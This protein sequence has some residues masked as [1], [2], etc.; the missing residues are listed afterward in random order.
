MLLGGCGKK[1]PDHLQIK[2]PE[3]EQL[4]NIPITDLASALKVM[5]RKDPLARAPKLPDPAVLE[6]LDG[7]EPVSA[8]IRQ[9]LR[10]EKGDGQVQRDLQELEEEFPRTAVVALSRG[11]RLRVVE[12][13]IA[14]I[15]PG[16]ESSESQIL[17]L[18]TPL[19]SSGNEA[20]LPRPPLEWL[21]GAEPLPTTVRNTSERWV[22]TAWLH[23]PN[24]PVQVIGPQMQ[25]PLYDGL[26]QTPTGQLVLARVNR[27]EGP[28]DDGLTAL[29]NATR[30]ALTRAAA[31]R[32]SEQA[33]WSE[34]KKA[35]AAEL[36]S[37]VPVAAYIDLALEPLIAAGGDDTAAGGALVAIGASRWEDSCAIQ[38]C[39]GLDR[40][41]TI[42]AAE[43]WG[44]IACDAET[45]QVIALKESLDT[46]DVGHDT[47]LFPR[48]M[49]DLA[50]ALIGT[51]AGP[52]E[53]QLVRRRTP[54]PAVWLALGR[55][56]GTEAVT[57][58]EG[59]RVAL[60]GHLEAQAK[61]AQAACDDDELAPLFERIIRRAVP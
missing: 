18:I 4:A 16:Q 26:S 9:I 43:A 44:N 7:A 37:D 46:M 45:W 61:Q 41:E 27:A 48:A 57:D 47:V 6:P 14:N 25:T 3:H 17:E 30:L 23:G 2:P 56:V 11:Y 60:G 49:V 55:A 29:R 51:A 33:D 54:D 24:I 8:Y 22:L 20:T 10:L 39:R 58:W 13:L 15:E 52:L 40:V 32:D 59:A 12:N 21:V 36:G 34:K 28:S 31:D 19:R 38:P 42:R 53:A 35:A 50:D 5:V 1:V